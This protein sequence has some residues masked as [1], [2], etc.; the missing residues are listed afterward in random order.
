MT[1]EDELVVVVTPAVEILPRVEPAL[2]GASRVAEHLERL[3]EEVVAQIDHV[4]VDAS[5]LDGARQLLR[6][7]LDIVE[8]LEDGCRENDVDSRE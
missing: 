4:D 5:R 7:Q 8:V 6:P 1:L 3:I 2:P